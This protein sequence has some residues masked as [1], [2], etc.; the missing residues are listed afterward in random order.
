MI[1]KKDTAKITIRVSKPTNQAPSASCSAEPITGTKPLTVYFTGSGSDTD[2]YIESYYWTFGDGET[3][4]L[5]SPSHTFQN[6][7]M[8]TV[9]LTVTD[10]DGSKGSASVE[11]TVIEKLNP[12]NFQVKSQNLEIVDVEPCGYAIL[13]ATIQN[14]G[15]PGRQKVWASVTNHDAFGD[16]NEWTYKR[17]ETP[18]LEE[19]ESIVLTYSFL[20]ACI[21]EGDRLSNK[22]WIEDVCI[23]DDE[24]YFQIVYSYSES[25]RFQGIYICNLG[26]YNTGA[27]GRK[28]VWISL[29]QTDCEGT[30]HK[31][32]Q[33]PFLESGEV[34]ELTY[35]FTGLKSECDYGIKWWV[36]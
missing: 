3:S 25:D 32:V 19:D 4:N 20:D 2:G 24:P 10:D 9:T 17:L 5:A 27:S 16:G 23:I 31:K 28:S 22:V 12:P 21:G 13:E 11:I 36:E 33:T 35:I 1:G 30:L 26:V 29:N 14:N 8:Y 7:G 34:L 6:S 18:Y 15:G